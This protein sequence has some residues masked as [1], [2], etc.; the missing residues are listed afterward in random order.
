MF[1]QREA[2]FRPDSENKGTVRNSIISRREELPQYNSSAQFNQ[3]YAMGFGLYS[4][5]EKSK[6]RARL[7][8]EKAR[9]EKQKRKLKKRL[10]K[11]KPQKRA[12]EEWKSSHPKAFNICQNDYTP[13]YRNLGLQPGASTDAIMEAWKRTSSRSLALPP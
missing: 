13:H 1:R 9:I 8:K 7:E 5:P 4:E 6:A 12:T 10:P 2:C 3:S 11:V